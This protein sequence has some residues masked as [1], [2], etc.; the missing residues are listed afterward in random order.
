MNDE[1]QHQQNS[2]RHS[3]KQL[4]LGHMRKGIHCVAR[5]EQTAGQ[6]PAGRTETLVCVGRDQALSVVIECQGWSAF[7]STT[8]ALQEKYR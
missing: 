8:V 4:S 3:S 6:L 2:M 7:G 5:R 1:G